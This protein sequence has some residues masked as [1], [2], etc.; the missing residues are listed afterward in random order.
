[1]ILKSL[2]AKL[3]VVL[4]ALFF[5]VGITFVLVS[6]YSTEMYQQEVN[7]KLNRDLAKLIVAENIVLEDNKVNDKA[8]KKLFQISGR[9]NRLSSAR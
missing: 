6:V 1:M 9:R 2:Y 5:M 3:A 8:L 4:L 7:Q